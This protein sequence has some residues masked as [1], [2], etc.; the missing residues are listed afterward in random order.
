MYL[1]IGIY[2]WIIKTSI[3]GYRV[4]KVFRRCQEDVG[5]QAIGNK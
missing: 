4:G 1:S 5:K 2:P 3:D